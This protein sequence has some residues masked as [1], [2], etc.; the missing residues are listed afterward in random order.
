MIDKFNLNLASFST[1]TALSKALTVLNSS[2]SRCL[3]AATIGEPATGFC[4]NAVLVSFLS[5]YLDFV[6]LIP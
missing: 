3:I 1:I 6:L 2:G 5:V 4:K